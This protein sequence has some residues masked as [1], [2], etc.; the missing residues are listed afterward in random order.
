MF[1]KRTITPVSFASMERVARAM[2]LQMQDLFDSLKR[3]REEEEEEEEEE[4]VVV[5]A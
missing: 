3:K 4:V 1:N 2:L 5:V